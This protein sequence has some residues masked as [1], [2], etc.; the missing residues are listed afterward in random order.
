MTHFHEPFRRSIEKWRA[1]A[2]I[3]I[4]ACSFSLTHAE[5]LYDGLRH[6]A[7]AESGFDFDGIELDVDGLPQSVEN[8]NDAADLADGGQTHPH[9]HSE[10]AHNATPEQK[11]AS[12]DF[13]RMMLDGFAIPPLNT[14]SVTGLTRLYAGNPQF[15]V[16]SMQRAAPYIHEIISELKRRGMPTDLALLPVIESSYDPR[17][18]SPAAAAGIWQFIPE[19]G[20]RYGLRQDWLRDERRDPMAATR[21]AL[22]YLKFLY[23]MFG[24]WHLAL[25]GYNCGENCVARAIEKSRSLGG[26]RDFAS[27]AHFLPQETRD[28]V[29]RFIA[30]RNVFRTARLQLPA[31]HRNSRI[32]AI[33]LNHPVDLISLANLAGMSYQELKTLNAGVLRQVVPSNSGVIWITEEGLGRLKERL[34]KA[35]DG[36]D[37]HLLINLK[38]VRAYPG[39]SLHAFAARHGLSIQEVRTINNIHPALSV[40]SSGTLFV[41]RRSDEAP[42]TGN[43]GDLRPLVMAGEQALNMRI[44]RVS[45]SRNQ[46]TAHPIVNSD[47]GWIPGRLKIGGSRSKS[48]MKKLR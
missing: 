33:M 7:F 13:W 8:I 22:D 37:Q 29:P 34:A 46:L 39:E 31:I 12:I 27:I 2:C 18:I 4:L 26:G 10:Q 3:P 48:R 45:D 43:A 32:T 16:R 25:A 40:I 17:A 9:E 11:G 19:T 23:G 24:D 47:S 42:F 36:I 44:K 6:A 14:D 30:V 35:E 5:D 15:L 20:R 38:A 21:A 41:P 28:Y 1:Y